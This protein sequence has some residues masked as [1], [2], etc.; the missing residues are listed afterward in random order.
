MATTLVGNNH[1]VTL[2]GEALYNDKIMCSVI[3]NGVTQKYD[4]NLDDIN[5]I[6]YMI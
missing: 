3:E 1:L 4:M 2:E 6:F 5:M